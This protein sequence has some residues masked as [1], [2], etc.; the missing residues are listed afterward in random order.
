MVGQTLSN[1]QILPAQITLHTPP[2]Q[3]APG[4]PLNAAADVTIASRQHQIETAQ[5]MGAGQK[6]GRKRKLK[7][8]GAQTLN[9][10]SSLL[11]SAGSIPGVD[12]TNSHIKAVDTLNAIRAAATGDKLANAAPYYPAKTGGKRTKR[13]AKHGRRNH[14]THRRGH[15]KSAGTRRRSRRTV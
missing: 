8:G 13:R 11:P 6:G 5:K 14:R 12:P 9:A 3:N 7:R 4:G 15:N 2:A 1:G 10:P